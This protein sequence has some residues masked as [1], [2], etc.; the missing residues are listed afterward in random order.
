MSP[1]FLLTA[2]AWVAAAAP[3][4]LCEA[5]EH[6]YFS[7]A[8]SKTKRL[9]L[10]GSEPGAPTAWLQYR[11]GKVGALELAFPAKKEGSLKAFL[12]ERHLHVNSMSFAVRFVNGG[13]SYLL[14]D[15]NTMG[16]ATDHGAGVLIDKATTLPDG[17][18]TL[19]SAS[20]T[21]SVLCR[22]EA[23]TRLDLEVLGATLVHG[24]DDQPEPK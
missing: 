22:D 14:F 2:V 15:Q 17:G 8:T 11:F 23:E 1:S 24:P 9:A 7:C 21:V 18:V 10:C 12:W 6:Q 16:S 20:K 3:A 4:S 5:H 19:A 13:F